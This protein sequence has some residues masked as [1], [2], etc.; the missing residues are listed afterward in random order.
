M[1]LE[2]QRVRRTRKLDVPLSRACDQPPLLPCFQGTT[3]SNIANSS[4]A[5]A[6]AKSRLQQR[7]SVP[8]VQCR[9]VSIFAQTIWK[10]FVL[11]EFDIWLLS[12]DFRTPKQ[13]QAMATKKLL[14]KQNTH[15]SIIVS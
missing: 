13:L 14:V 9:R 11:L 8:P 12:W 3:S 6:T 2:K 5:N 4:A 7:C 1:A 15:G 10:M